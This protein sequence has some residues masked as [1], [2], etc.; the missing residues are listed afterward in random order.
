MQV[1]F[2][3][4]PANTLA[5]RYD[6]ACRLAETA[7]RQQRQVYLH[8]T[9]HDLAVQLDQQLWNFRPDAFLPHRLISEEGPAAPVL[10]GWQVDEA[11]DPG[12]VL[13]NLSASVPA[14]FQRF[15]RVAE[16]VVQTPEVLAATRHHWR[17]Y[18]QYGCAP[19]KH[20]MAA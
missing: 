14:C 17:T 9:D 12:D 13:I 2:Y 7:W 4:L 10:I 1:D 20:D 11:P 16:I 8:V 3:I 19:C 15:Q 5:A 6:F 18:Q